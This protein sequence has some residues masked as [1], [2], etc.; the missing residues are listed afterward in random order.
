MVWGQEALQRSTL[1]AGLPKRGSYLV[2]LPP[3]RN[4]LGGWQVVHKGAGGSDPAN[5]YVILGVLPF[6]CTPST[7]NRIPEIV[8]ELLARTVDAY[9]M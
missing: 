2:A 1:C 7:Q 8:F 9:V 3:T 5:H 6:L 4:S